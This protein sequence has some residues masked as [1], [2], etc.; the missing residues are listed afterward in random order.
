MRIDAHQHF[1]NHERELYPWIG[2]T[3]GVLARDYGPLDL[4]PELA[5]RGIDGS[6]VVQA[7]QDDAETDWLLELAREHDFLR[8]VVGWVDLATEHVEARL[9]ALA[10]DPHLVGVRHVLQDEPD[11]DHMLRPAFQ[12]GIGRLAR[13][14]LVYDIL[15]FPRHLQRASTLVAAFPEQA[16]V[17][18][19]VAKPLIAH[20]VREPWA[21]H[22]RALAAHPN[23]SCKL[24]GMVTEAT[25]NA[26]QPADFQPYLDIAYE[27]FG[28]DRVMF[29][30][31]WPVCLLSASYA[32]VADVVEQWA[33]QLGDAQ[34]A[35]L[36]GLNAARVYG[37]R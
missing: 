37:L 27:A 18:D 21:A 13:R 14:G 34:R 4:A 15:I 3:M 6:V 30:S 19:H 2:P 12:R 24:S 22:L 7:R 32:R 26:W 5:A 11:D 20:G 29:G 17:L 31:D 8:G 16:F 9:D 23:V 33:A 1:W 10:G 35:K 36:F 28:E 25:W